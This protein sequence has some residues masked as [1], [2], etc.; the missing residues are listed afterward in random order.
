MFVQFNDDNRT[1]IKSKLI[2]GY[3]KMSESQINI[4]IGDSAMMICLWYNITQVNFGYDLNAL[5]TILEPKNITELS[6]KK[7]EQHREE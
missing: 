3:Q 6:N 5:Q 4:Y 1:T 7:L 2:S